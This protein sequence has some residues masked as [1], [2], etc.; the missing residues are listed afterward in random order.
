M[1]KRVPGPG[2]PGPE[3]LFQ[4]CPCCEVVLFFGEPRPTR[5]SARDEFGAQ[6]PQGVARTGGRRSAQA[7]GSAASAPVVL[8]RALRSS[9]HSAPTSSITPSQFSNDQPRHA[10]EFTT[11]AVTSVS[12]LRRACAAIERRSSDRDAPD[13]FKMGAD[14][15]GLA[16]IITSNGGLTK[17]SALRNRSIRSTFSAIRAA[18]QPRRTIVRAAPANGRAGHGAAGQSLSEAV[19]HLWGRP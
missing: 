8:R 1:Q 13:D 2:A 17:I 19:D 6:R 11:L 9:S 16:R 14:E 15:A 4:A 10:L 12:P 7:A 3:R 18:F 5:T